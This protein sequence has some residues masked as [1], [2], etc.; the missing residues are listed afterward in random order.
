MEQAP[1]RIVPLIIDAN[2]LFSIIGLV[3]TD[4]GE[5]IKNIIV[6]S[7]YCNGQYPLGRFFCFL[8]QA[9]FLGCLLAYECMI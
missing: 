4:L 3:M 7:G 8:I 6:M 5:S 2:E 1:A 9:P